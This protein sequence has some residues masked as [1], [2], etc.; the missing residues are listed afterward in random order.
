MKS[1]IINELKLLKE[2]L[3][4]SSRSKLVSLI[5]ILNERSKNYS[6]PRISYSSQ[7]INVAKK[8]LNRF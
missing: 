7:T 1:I 5:K 3:I 6:L 2:V 8:G 4:Y